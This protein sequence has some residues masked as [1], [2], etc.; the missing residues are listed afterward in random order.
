MIRKQIK[1]LSVRSVRLVFFCP[2]ARYA[3]SSA[4]DQTYL[5]FDLE[6]DLDFR[7]AD[8]LGPLEHAE[9]PR[10]LRLRPLPEKEKERERASE[11]FFAKDMIRSV[12]LLHRLSLSVSW[13]CALSLLA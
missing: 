2:S 4:G 11:F 12:L 8:F 5:L 7:L 6:R 13:Q 3:Y 1:F 10:L 9:A